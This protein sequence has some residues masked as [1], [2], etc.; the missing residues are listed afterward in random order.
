MHTDKKADY[1]V[2]LDMGTGSL[3]G[4]VTDPHYHLMKVKGTA[5]AGTEN[6]QNLQKKI[7]ASSG[8]NRITPVLFC[9]GGAETRST[10]LYP[11]G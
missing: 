2:G 6:T 11:P 3:G 10:L 8:K 5:T 9:R 7:T 4:A 1:Y